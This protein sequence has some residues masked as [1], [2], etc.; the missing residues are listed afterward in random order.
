MIGTKQGEPVEFLFVHVPKLSNYYKLTD[1]YTYVNYL[2]VG[3]FALCDQLNRN[4]IPAR[5]KHLGLETISAPTFSIAQWVKTNRI[6]V[7]GMSLHWHFQSFDVI[8]VAK[9]IKAASPETVIVLGGLTASRFAAEIL[10][11]FEQ[12]DA[13]ICGDG[14]KG[15]VSFAKTVQRGTRD[16][17]S[18]ENCIWRSKSGNIVENGISFVADAEALSSYDFANL[19][20]LDHHEQYRDY[21]KMPM[22]WMN[23]ASVEENLK[24]RMASETMFPLAIG[25]GC[26]VNCSYCGGGYSAHKKLCGREQYALRSVDSIV[27]TMRSAMGYGYTGFISS[28]D[29]TPKDDRYYLSLLE[30]MR[31]EKV[32]P[33]YGLEFWGL[34][35]ERIIESFTR[36]VDM[37]RSY[38]ALSPESGSEKV[39]RRN[40]GMYYSNDTLFKTMD[41]LAEYKVPTVI[42]FTIGLVDETAEDIR[43]TIALS[44]LLKKKWKKEVVGVLCVPIQIEPG[45]PMFEDPEKHGLVSTRSTFMDFYHSHSRSDSGPFSYLGYTNKAYPEAGDDPKAYED[46]LQRIRCKNFCLLS[47]RLFG[48]IEMGLLSRALCRL[49]HAKWKK[50]GFGR[51]PLQR[52]TFK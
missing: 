39:R 38:I 49:R 10:D 34:P 37:R 35:S 44:A 41:L 46:A 24:I 4:G 32:K 2:P 9:K 20:L 31:R 1:E 29:P 16:Y 28:F 45:S 15:V 21:Y 6:P 40:K 14:D 51:V 7:V 3:V 30:T 42:Y 25:R 48:K 47:P 27:K 33:G 43:K 13:V 52:R 50:A 19:S 36:T 18:V 8:D 12:I 23:N 22:F 26:P 11:S 5:I 17:S